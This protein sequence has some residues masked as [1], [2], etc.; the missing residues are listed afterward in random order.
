MSDD[1]LIGDF[2]SLSR[3]TKLGHELLRIW[4]DQR[5]FNLLL[6]KPPRDEEQTTEQA[7][8]FV[9]W[10][11]DE[12]HEML[13][14]M[15]WKKHRK[16]QHSWNEAHIHEE[17]IDAFKLMISI[18]Q[19]IGV[20]SLEKLIE[21]YWRKTAVVQQRYREEW[22]TKLDGT[23]VIVDIDN[24]ICDYVVGMCEWLLKDN[25]HIWGEEIG[26]STELRKR[27][28]HCQEI[29]CFIC[30]ESLG[31]SQDLWQ[32]LKH[33]FRID[34]IKRH[35]PVFPDARL[36]LERMRMDGHR[37][38]L[39]TSR[40]IDRY[41]NI[42]TDTIFWLNENRL[43]YDFVWWSL[44]KAERIVQIEDLRPR[45]RFAV[46]DDPKFV[47]Q[48]ADLGIETY[49]LHRHDTAGLED[50]SFPGYAITHPNV[51]IVRSLLDVDKD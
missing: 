32:K 20:D 4:D 27:I 22:M 12:L 36:F 29:R 51:H 7:R 15:P 9:L 8:D 1:A 33:L 44:D 41:P 47:R 30:A 40:P 43:P 19:L 26:P 13:R 17:G 5:A 24:V 50:S 48:F 35:L 39:L 16:V 45:I 31:I 6:R 18:L 23:C 34:G 3:R 2:E 25:E 46:D 14:A 37:I 28:Q 38:V 11:E 49:W 10:T 42:F 21:V